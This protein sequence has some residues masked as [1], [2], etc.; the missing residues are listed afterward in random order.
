MY[1]LI[2]TLLDKMGN[3]FG[4]IFK[5]LI[6]AIIMHR[7]IRLASFTIYVYGGLITGNVNLFHDLG[8]MSVYLFYIM[9][10]LLLLF[11][12]KAASVFEFVVI[13]YYF[14]NLILLSTVEYFQVNIVGLEDALQ[15]Y[16]RMA[17]L[18]AVFLVCKILFYFFVILNRDKM[19][20]ERLSKLDDKY[21]D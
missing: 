11:S 4:I 18:V 15:P 3:W 17:P 13:P 1:K 20:E 19:E 6:P 10:A 12:P 8:K 14:L 7:P 16:I 9:L 21:I 5:I 2:S